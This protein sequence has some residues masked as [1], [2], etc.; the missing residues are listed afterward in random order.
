[1]SHDENR[2][3]Y[4]GPGG[5]S[6]VYIPLHDHEGAQRLGSQSRKAHFS[7]SAVDRARLRA[8]LNGHKGHVT[9]TIEDCHE[10]TCRDAV[11]MLIRE[12]LL[13]Q[14]R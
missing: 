14:L 12:G 4:E 9:S 10:P 3:I 1:V 2:I 11:T 7:P 13:E 6:R 8:S 5:R